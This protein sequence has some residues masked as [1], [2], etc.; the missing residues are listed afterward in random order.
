MKNKITFLIDLKL[1]LLTKKENVVIAQKTK[2]T[3]KHA[4]EEYMIEKLERMRLISKKGF[5]K[6]LKLEDLKHFKVRYKVTGNKKY[7]EIKSYRNLINTLRV[8]GLNKIIN[9]M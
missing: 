4:K 6:S 8:A 7:K 3:T 9:E 2:S 1:K 5:K